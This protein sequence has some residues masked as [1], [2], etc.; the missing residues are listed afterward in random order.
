MNTRLQVEH[1]VTEEVYN[2]D[3][4]KEQIKVSLGEKLAFKQTGISPQG[5]SMECRINAE[6]PKTFFPSSGI[7]STHHAPG[8]PGIR[9]DSCLYSGCNITSFYD[10][11]IAKLIASGKN[12]KECIMRLKRALSEYVIEG[13]ETNIPLFKRILEEKTFLDG[14]FHINW[15]EQL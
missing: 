5:H 3:I 12:R 14:E 4:V 9:I 15:L 10:G 1:T 13:V 6:N 11:M 2:L 8:G 7:V